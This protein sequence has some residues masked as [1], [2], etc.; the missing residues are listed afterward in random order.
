MAD[1]LKIYINRGHSNTDP[2]AVKYEQERALVVKVGD[3]MEA[4][5]KA[6]YQCLIKSSS[7]NVNSLTTITNEANAWGADIFVSI[8]FNAGGGDGA[9]ILVYS[10]SNKALGEI[11]DKHIKAIG[12]NSRGIKCRPDLGVL[13][14]TKMKAVLIECA[15]VDNWKDIQDWNDNAEL[16]KMGE[17]IAKATAEALKLPKKVTYTKYVALEVMNHRAKP[18]TSG[19]VYCTIPTGTILKVQSVDSDGWG[20]VSYNDKT[21]YVRIKSSTKTYCKRVTAY[22]TLETMNHRSKAS[23]SGALI[24]TIPT[25]TTIYVQSVDSDGWGKLIYKGKT[26][27]VRIKSSTKTYCKKV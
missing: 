10:T 14:L 1:L 25:G 24:C 26:G 21:G 17:A 11:F 13:R 9:E 15:F 4:Y 22:K 16:K 27:Y 7:G 18:N 6:N 23:T 8:H 19:T 2:G 3:Y 5:L 20:K 12:Q